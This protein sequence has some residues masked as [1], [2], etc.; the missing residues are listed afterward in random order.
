MRPS[1]RHICVRSTETARVARILA[2]ARQRCT[3]P[4][5]P[6]YENYGGRGIRFCDSL[7]GLPGARL[8]LEALGPRP[9]AMHTLDRIDNNGDYEIGNVR[10]ATRQQ[11]NLNRRGYGMHRGDDSIGKISGTPCFDPISK[12][13]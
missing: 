9:S 1:W 2:S 12:C 10:W 11:Q 4:K 7:V 5:I 13:T 3:N 8:L 6:N